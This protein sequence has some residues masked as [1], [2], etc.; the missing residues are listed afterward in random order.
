VHFVTVKSLSAVTSDEDET[1]KL[2]KI[3]AMV[4][5]NVCRTRSKRCVAKKGW[6]ITHWSGCRANGDLVK[7]S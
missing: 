5:G 7:A 3:C 6:L 2:K 4:G 1:S